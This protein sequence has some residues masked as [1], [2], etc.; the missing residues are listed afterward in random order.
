MRLR[1]RHSYTHDDLRVLRAV[2]N[3]LNGPAVP[4]A[5]Q[6]F[7]IPLLVDPAAI[8]IVPVQVP[9]ELDPGDNGQQPAQDEHAPDKGQPVDELPADPAPKASPDDG[10]EEYWHEHVTPDPSKG[11]GN[12]VEEKAVQALQNSLTVGGSRRR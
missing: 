6:T 7:K 2:F 4:R 1:G 5:G 11:P 9:V 10:A 8:Y 3:E 12:E